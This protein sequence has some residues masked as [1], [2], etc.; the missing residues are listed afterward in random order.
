M[1]WVSVSY[2]ESAFVVLDTPVQIKSAGSKL[3]I[4]ELLTISPDCCAGAFDVSTG[5]CELRGRG[6][7]EDEEREEAEVLQ[8]ELHDDELFG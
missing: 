6:D 5:V 8:E 7:R 3:T 4:L 1:R 2:L